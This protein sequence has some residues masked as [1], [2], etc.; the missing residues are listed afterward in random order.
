M[1]SSKV[2]LWQ[3]KYTLLSAILKISLEKISSTHKI[4]KILTLLGSQ[5]NPINV[6][7]TALFLTK[8]DLLHFTAGYNFQK[9][10]NSSPSHINA[11]HYGIVADTTQ[12]TIFPKKRISSPK[13][14]PVI[15]DSPHYCISL[16][17]GKVKL[18]VLVVFCQETHDNQETVEFLEDIAHI[19]EII[20][21]AINAKTQTTKEMEEIASAVAH[22]VRN[23]LAGIRGM[24]QSIEEEVSATSDAHECTTRIIRQVDRLNKLLCDFFS[25]VRPQK[26]EIS[27]IDVEAIVSDTRA[28]VEK[29]LCHAKIH[30]QFEA[31]KNIPTIIADPNQLQQILLNLFLNSID[32]IK[33][34]GLISLFIEE[35]T[36]QQQQ[37]YTHQ[38]QDLKVKTGDILLR[39]TDN[40]PGISQKNIHHIFDPFFTTKKDGTGLGLAT[41]Y[42]ILKENRASIFAKSSPES[43]TTFYIFFTHA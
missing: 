3:S 20:L 19:I 7:H 32:A 34:N 28:L 41:V 27:Q 11:Y 10:D 37:L 12:T 6:Q 26:S 42:R 24:A 43:G 40:G 5:L 36:A 39:F 2:D 13:K 30:F 16:S 25:Y 22:E 9:C 15:W 31:Q 29:K 4:D 17:D 35:V 8:D 23:P 1:K 14:Q 38:F 18:G 33:E 21:S